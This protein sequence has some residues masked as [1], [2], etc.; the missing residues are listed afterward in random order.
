M[1]DL[2]QVSVNAG[3]AEVE[4]LMLEL[5]QVECPVINKFE[6]GIYYRTITMP[7]GTYVIGHEHKTGHANIVLKGKA[8]VA[9]DG[10]IHLIEAP[11]FFHSGPGVRKVLEILEEC[12]WMTVHPNPDNEQD[13][14]KLEE[15][16]ITK[17]PAWLLKAEADLK[18]LQSTQET[19]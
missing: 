6:E 4:K 16:F 7:K 9:I 2:V 11:K 19:K 8:R 1:N 10:E 17:S 14:Q 18:K 3:I 15:R 13:D 12:V 5:P